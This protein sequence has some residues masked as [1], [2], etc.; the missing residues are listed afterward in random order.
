MNLRPDPTFHPTSQMPM[1]APVE[2]LAFTLMLGPD[3]TQPDGLAV[4]DL[5]PKS[6]T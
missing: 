3:G 4:I 2:T 1:E 6:T 5:D